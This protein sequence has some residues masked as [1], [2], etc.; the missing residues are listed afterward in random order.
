MCHLYILENGGYIE[1]D[2]TFLADGKFYDVIVGRKR[3][4]DDEKQA[5]T[6]WE[7]EFGR[8]NLKERGEEFLSRMR[9]RLKDI[10]SF[11][12]REN[13]QEKSRADL[14]DRKARLEKVL[15][16]EIE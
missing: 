14:M 2:F 1:R 12:E 6:V 5:Y 16:D 11:L 15:N 9:R 8:G 7:I 3:A 4:L 13:L 10:E